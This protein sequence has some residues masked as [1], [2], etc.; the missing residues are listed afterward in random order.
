MNSRNALLLVLSLIVLYVVGGR[1][2]A[3][4]SASEIG[5]VLAGT[6]S[7]LGRDGFADTAALEKFLATPEIKD[8]RETVQRFAILGGGYKDRISEVQKGL[9]YLSEQMAQPEE[10]RFERLPVLRYFK[11]EPVSSS[12]RSVSD[13][14]AKLILDFRQQVSG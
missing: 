8:R 13:A 6:Y 3:R 4:K 12:D 1:L 14:G 11:I 2:Y 10:K 7:M 5:A 9:I